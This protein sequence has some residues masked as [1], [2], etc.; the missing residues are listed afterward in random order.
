MQCTDGKVARARSTAF[1]F[2][3]Q[4]CESLLESLLESRVKCASQSA[5]LP[6]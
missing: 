2:L 4:I 3:S 6:L 1:T 5:A